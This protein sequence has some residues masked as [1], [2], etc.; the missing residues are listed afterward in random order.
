M[1]DQTGPRCGNNPNF[2]MSDGDRKVVEE[3]QA[4]LTLKAVVTP[5]LET[6]AWVDGDPLMEVIAHAVHQ[7]CETGDGGIVHDDPRNIAAVA[8]LVARASDAERALARVRTVLETEHVVGRSALEYRG[9]I[10]AALMASEPKQ[11]GAQR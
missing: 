2:R 10:T 5:L 3:F 4:F 9:L 11:D 8:A 1:T 7:R 6:A